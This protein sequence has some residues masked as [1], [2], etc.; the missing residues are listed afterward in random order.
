MSG[1][2]VHT[3]SA[4]YREKYGQ[5]V[6]KIA[7]ETGIPCPNRRR[8]GCIYCSPQSFRPASLRSGDP[9]GE[10]LRKGR[11]QLRDRRKLRIYLAYFQQETSTAG[12]PDELAEKFRLP[13]LDP[14]CKGLILSTRPDALGPGILDRIAALRDEMPGKEFLVELGLQ[15]AHDETLRLLNRNHTYED[16]VQAVRLLRTLPFVQVGVHLILCLPGE[17]APDMLD[18]VRRVCGLGVDYMKLH[19]LQVIRGTTLHEMAALNPLKPWSA[20]QYV[21]LLTLL[22]P[23]IPGRVVMH[24][25]W[26]NADPELL[27]EPRWGLM[28]SALHER[29]LRRMK[30]E[31]VTQGCRAGNPSVAGGQFFPA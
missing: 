5:P 3:F 9:L 24:R 8:G 17:E 16:F 1:S 26:S 20:E 18:T 29:V 12:P 13:L 19:H 30:A 11:L 14:D 25:L 6:G 2:P 22:L 31:G 15:S 4:H 21:D 7:L 27:V 23:A 10:Q 28:T